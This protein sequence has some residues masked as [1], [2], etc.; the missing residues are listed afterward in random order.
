MNRR[1][2]AILF[3]DMAGFSRAMGEDETATIDALKTT[4]DDIIL[5]L[6]Q[7]FGGRLVKDMGDGG[8][9]EFTSAVD[10]VR[11]AIAMQHAVA[12]K[13]GPHAPSSLRYRIGIN[14]GDV[15]EDGDDLLGDGVNIASRLEGLAQPGGICVHQTVRDQVAGKLA[16]DF[17][18]LGLTDLKN[19]I[20]PVAAFA[21]V[22]NDKTRTLANSPTEPG[23]NINRAPA[24]RPTTL[25]RTT[26]VLAALA[27]FIT[28]ALAILWWQPWTSK[29]QQASVDRMAFPLPD[30]PSLAVLPFDDMSENHGQGHF[31][32]GLTED[33]ITDLSRI[34]G[35][36][37]VARNS[38]FVYK[39]QSVNIAQVAEALGV[40][41]VLEGSVRRAGDQVRVNAQLI[42][43]T[44][45]GHVWA[46][47]F[48]GDVSDIF[49]VQ[50]QFI[51]KIAKALA[52]NLTEAEKQDIA[53][54]Q[55]SNLDAREVFQ[56]GWDSY[57]SYSADDNANAVTKFK[58]AL[59]IDPAYGRAHAALS[60]A[61]LR[62]CQQRWHGALGMSTGEANARAQTALAKTKTHP[63]TLANVAAS[64]VN[65][66][67]SNYQVA[68]T[69]ATR[70]IARDPNDP[71]GY[72][73]M[74]WA[75]ITTNQADAGL[76]L[77]DRAIR[78]NPTYPNYYILAL[79]MAH[80][81]LGDLEQAS[82]VLA[83]ALERDRGALE[84]AAVSASLHGLLGRP[85]AAHA[86]MKIWLPDATDNELAAAPYGYHFPFA[87]MHRPEMVRR[88]VDGLHLAALPPG[89]QIGTLSRALASEN[90]KDRH[91]AATMLGRFGPRAGPAVPALITALDDDAKIVRREAAVTLGK[92]G[93]A[94]KAAL[95]ALQ[96]VVGQP[97]VGARAKKAIK[98]I[99]GE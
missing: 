4:C 30:K 91:K 88:I 39:N 20:H 92:I 33:L 13:D 48:D 10:A 80:Y 12:R 36:F 90:K 34:S 47:R 99:S 28:L 81:T 70:A 62:G 23:A 49:S 98:Q 60:L 77:M 42:D 55:T 43:A 72:V 94:A 37:V 19:I 66:Y 95:P 3:Y 29:L 26:G 74:A 31:A 96:N 84:L 1:L 14:I 21:V 40:R 53:L 83:D 44:T 16:I 11:F 52:V 93:P 64:R 85:D 97:I 5:P 45:G 25:R 18:D 2:A 56:Q 89:D 51:R 54:G 27:A 75:M 8:F 7:R 58:A 67:N 71:E 65:L 79:A 59:T 68:Q 9:L 38:T 41:Y 78:Q 15:V 6:A 63:S 76:E 46:D 35:L 22:M 82:V 24:K 17:D 87:W 32:D 69:E 73:A 50:D 86:A 57:L 61:Y